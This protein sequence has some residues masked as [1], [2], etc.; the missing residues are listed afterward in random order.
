MPSESEKLLEVAATD[1]AAPGVEAG[2]AA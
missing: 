1:V 2:R